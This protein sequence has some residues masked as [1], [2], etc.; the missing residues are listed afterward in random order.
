MQVKIVCIIFFLFAYISQILFYIQDNALAVARS[1]MVTVSLFFL[2]LC[3][4]FLPIPLAY[5]IIFC[6]TI[7]YIG[8]INFHLYFT[9]FY[10]L[11]AGRR[12]DLFAREQIGNV[13]TSHFIVEENFTLLPKFPTIVICNYCFDRA[14]N[15]MPIFIP[16]SFAFLSLDKFAQ[17]TKIDRVL[18]VLITRGGGD[19]NSG[20]YE[21]M[22]EKIR[23]MI[24]RKRWIF[25]YV[26]RCCKETGVVTKLRSGM[27]Y[28][29]QELGLGIT[30]IYIDYLKMNSGIIVPQKFRFV[31]KETFFIKQR[32]EIQQ[33]IENVRNFFV[34]EMRK[35]SNS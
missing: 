23:E 2:L 21:K 18:E 34:E 25:S 17:Y 28:I 5:K 31:V 13:L 10:L 22:K 24:Q 33:Q 8:R 6:T 1:L 14:E 29:A 3:I 30:P 35:K 12:S 4:I 16:R 32:E 7:L 9:F 11:W 26:N 27:F 20:E 15:L 19:R